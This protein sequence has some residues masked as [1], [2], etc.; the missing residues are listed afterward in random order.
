METKISYYKIIDS[1]LITET[2]WGVP[3]RKWTTI[4]EIHRISKQQ[5]HSLAGRET[6]VSCTVILKGTVISWREGDL[7]KFAN[8]LREAVTVDIGEWPWF[9][10]D[11]LSAGWNLSGH[12]KVFDR[13]LQQ[14]GRQRQENTNLKNCGYFATIPSSSHYSIFAK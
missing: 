1:V 10:L 6:K 7:Y 11:V 5:Q 9:N 13:E 4:K 8:L 3:D 12:H 14:R 2:H